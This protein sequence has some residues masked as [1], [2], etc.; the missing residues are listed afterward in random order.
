MN[1]L[2][3]KLPVTIEGGPQ[4]CWVDA[5]AIELEGISLVCQSDPQMTSSVSILVDTVDEC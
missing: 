2:S 4:D 1:V 5:E 3:Y